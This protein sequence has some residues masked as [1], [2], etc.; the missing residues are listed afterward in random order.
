MPFHEVPDLPPVL[1][2][3]AAAAVLGMSRS[4]AYALIRAGTW[5]T[6][7]LQLSRSF[8][9]PSAPLLELLGV[10]AREDDAGRRSA[11]PPGEE[12]S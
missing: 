1:G 5:P 4:T 6:P 8:R 3:A 10:P 2:V 11:Q 7:V 9:I 12:A